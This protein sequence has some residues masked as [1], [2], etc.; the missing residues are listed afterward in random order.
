M[1][2]TSS[3]WRSACFAAFG[4]AIA[5][6]GA[7]GLAQTP[8]VPDAPTVPVAPTLPHNAVIKEPLQPAASQ[9]I[10]EERPSP[11]HVWIAGHWRWQDGRYAWIAGRWDL[12]PR[13]NTVWIEPRWEQRG[14]GF[15]L[16]GGY[17]QETAPA[18]ANGVAVP[19]S[20]APVIV[21]STAPA[22]VAS[23]SS[24]PTVVVVEPPIHT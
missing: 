15:V 4:L 11:Q 2:T 1:R 18:A 21:A 7:R 9:E 6:L 10:I 23:P 19:T 12:P 14:N 22:P 20:S 24:P 3:L 5:G 13:A 17:W 16:A 8:G